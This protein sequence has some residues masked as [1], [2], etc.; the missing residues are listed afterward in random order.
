MTELQITCINK[1][2]RDNPYDGITHV[3]GQTWRITRAEAIAY[4]EKRTHSFFT[5]VNGN[6]GEVRVVEGANGKYL[7]TYADGREN[8][9]LLSLPECR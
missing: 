4:I 9:N 6:R 2:P 1:T 7:R 3:G 5:M 8:D